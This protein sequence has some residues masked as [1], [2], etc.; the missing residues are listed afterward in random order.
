M[1]GSVGVGVSDISRSSLRTP[2]ESTPS[3]GC[4]GSKAKSPRQ[5][6]FDLHIQTFSRLI[7]EVIA[8]FN[9]STHLDRADRKLLKYPSYTV[10]TNEGAKLKLTPVFTAFCKRP[11]LALLNESLANEGF[12]RRGLESIHQGM[13]HLALFILAI[14]Y[15]NAHEISRL[16]CLNISLRDFS[17]N[18]EFQRWVL[19]SHEVPP[20]GK[21]RAPNPSHRR[22]YSTSE[23]PKQFHRRLSSIPDDPMPSPNKSKEKDFYREIIYIEQMLGERLQT[24]LEGC[25]WE[26]GINDFCLQDNQQLIIEC[27]NAF[28][29]QHAIINMDTLHPFIRE[30]EMKGYC[31]I[32]DLRISQ[33]GVLFHSK[34]ES[35][36]SK[37]LFLYMSFNRSNRGSNNLSVLRDVE[38]GNW[39]FFGDEKDAGSPI[40]WYFQKTSHLRPV[41]GLSAG[42]KWLRDFYTW[43]FKNNPTRLMSEV[44]LDE[45]QREYILYFFRESIVRKILEQL[46]LKSSQG[47]DRGQGR[48]QTGRCAIL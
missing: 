41:L 20:L 14:P 35:Q 30:S 2:A 16:S 25:I 27:V 48:G 5:I 43:F 4:F 12:D 34:E 47:H 24:F 32:S 18:I 8:N 45:F 39:Q 42:L 31:V 13:K 28:I 21:K 36:D 26:R 1:E 17:K 46:P 6:E 44:S 37:P 22:F 38:R 19:R 9:S 11:I 29:Q 40:Q 23:E 3:S 33:E 15:L 7:A 10:K